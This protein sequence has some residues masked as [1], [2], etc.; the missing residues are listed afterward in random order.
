MGVSK[1]GLVVIPALNEA[2]T[3]ADV[4]GEIR[5]HAPGMDILVV[6]DSSTDGTR[7]A[8]RDAGA[9]VLSHPINLG[10][11]A[12]RQTGFKYARMKGYRRVVTVDGD[13]QH[14]PRSVPDLLAHLD[15]N[16]ADVVIGSRFTPGDRPERYRAPV[17]RRL[18]MILFAKITSALIGHRIT[19]TTSGYRAMNARAIALFATNWYPQTFPDADLLFIAHR[20][21]LRITEISARFREDPSGRSIHSGI[22]PIYY[23][24]KMCLS[25]LV[26]MLR[27]A[28]RQEEAEFHGS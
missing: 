19:D 4:I 9:T 12:A 15:R 7:A 14:D 18:G 2:A 22:T 5:R 10:D 25:L 16:E 26:N 20:A 27:R 3:V 23:V 6:D 13:G 21:G 8:A 11:G 17:D 24:F 28:P 1:D